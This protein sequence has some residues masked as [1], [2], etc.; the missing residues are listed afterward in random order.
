MGHVQL[1]HGHRGVGQA[2]EEGALDAGSVHF[3][4][5]LALDGSAQHGAQHLHSHAWRERPAGLSTAEHPQLGFTALP[6]EK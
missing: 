5:D 3:A 4:N 6:R 1:L 2:E